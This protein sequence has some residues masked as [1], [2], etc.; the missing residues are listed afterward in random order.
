M[1]QILLKN[2]SV[3]RLWDNRDLHMQTQC[4]LLTR[5][6]LLEYLRTDC[7]WPQA[8]QWVYIHARY[9]C[10]NL[11]A[12]ANPLSNWGGHATIARKTHVAKSLI[13]SLGD[14]DAFVAMLQAHRE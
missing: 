13:N 3:A 9:T 7:N 5:V 8:I 10:L 4:I 11:T 6:S 2:M 1:L 12:C 14:M